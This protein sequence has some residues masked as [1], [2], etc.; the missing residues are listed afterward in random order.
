MIWDDFKNLLL[1]LLLSEIRTTTGKVNLMSLGI[2][3]ISGLNSFLT[4]P[5]DFLPFFVLIVFSAIISDLVTRSKS[6]R[7]RRKK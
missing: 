2:I 3:L 7:R 1:G 5:M 4:N 6:R